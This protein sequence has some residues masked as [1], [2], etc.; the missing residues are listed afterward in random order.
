M[1][2]KRAKHI[3]D[4]QDP[5][6]DIFS[7]YDDEGVGEIPMEETS[8]TKF[9]CG[10]QLLSP[11]PKPGCASCR[12]VEYCNQLNVRNADAI[13]KHLDVLQELSD[14]RRGYGVESEDQ[15]RFQQQRIWGSIHMITCS[16]ISDLTKDLKPNY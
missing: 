2:S 12:V 14:D 10:C 11:N 4:E 1:D 5:K 6:D 15:L 16:A 13:R 8:T 7:Q 9:T 3:E